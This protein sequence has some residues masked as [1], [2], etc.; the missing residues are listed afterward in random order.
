MPV[1]ND[2]YLLHFGVKGM[3]WGHHK[4]QSKGPNQHVSKRLERTVYSIGAKL[5]PRELKYKVRKVTNRVNDD[6]KMLSDLTTK[7]LKQNGILPNNHKA[8]KAIESVGITAHKNAVYN[9]LDHKDLQNLKYT[10]IQLDTLEV[11]TVIWLLAILKLML[12]R[13][14]S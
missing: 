12:L 3:K 1:Y 2:E 6:V 4:A 8:L 9:N 14:P 13:Q 5:N 7:S 10:Q 11:L